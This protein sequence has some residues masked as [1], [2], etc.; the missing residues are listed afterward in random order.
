MAGRNIKGITVEIGGNTGPLQKALK[1][2]DRQVK[3]TQSNL[4][5]VD[6]LLKFS[7]SSTVLLKQKQEE[8]AKAVSG[9]K[10]RLTVLKKAQEQYKASGKD[11]NAPAYKALEREIVQTESKLKSL[12]REQRNFGSVTKQQMQQAAASVKKVSDNI[13]QIGSAMTRNVSVPIA[14]IGAAAIKSFE[15]VDDGMDTIIKKTGATGK[16]AKDLEGI[17]KNLAASM[18][19][20]LEDAGNAIGEVST[21][22]G[23]TGKKLENLS[24]LFLKFASIND[25]DVTTSIGN[26][27]RVMSQFD[28]PVS[29]AAGVLGVFTKTA[30]RTG[31]SVDDLCFI[32]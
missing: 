31:Q 21:R 2:V 23:V 7:P 1:D 18:N 12:E 9:T 13:S 19:V 28:I 10:D 5:D 30:Q 15:E 3:T 29:D 27:Q 24:G 26:L 17:Y 20:S 6:K 32:A 22:F 16:S 25:T 11:L 4:K 14:A 8:L